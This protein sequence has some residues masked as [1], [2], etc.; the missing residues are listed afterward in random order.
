MYFLFFKLWFLSS[1]PMPSEIENLPLGIG[2]RGGLD[3]DRKGSGLEGRDEDFVIKDIDLV[4][5]LEEG[6]GQ[7][8]CFSVKVWV[9]F[10]NFF[11]RGVLWGDASEEDFSFGTTGDVFGVIVGPV[12]SDISGVGVVEDFG[13]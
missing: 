8:S 2:D 9:R 6:F 7:E 12:V 4:F 3:E 1:L 11:S 5:D 10:L 13:F